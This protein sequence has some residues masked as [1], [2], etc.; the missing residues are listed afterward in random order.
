MSIFFSSTIKNFSVMLRF[1]PKKEGQEFTYKGHRLLTVRS[2]S[3]GY[4]TCYYCAMRFRKSFKNTSLC[5]K[6]HKCRPQK[7]VIFYYKDLGKIKK[8]KNNGKK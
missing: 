8:K 2:K 7:D 6:D 4:Y 3:D 5:Q 1:K